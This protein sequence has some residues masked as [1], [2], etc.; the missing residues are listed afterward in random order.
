MEFG[1]VKACLASAGM[2]AA[3]YFYEYLKDIL[4]VLWILFGITFVW[5][6]YLWIK[7]MNESQN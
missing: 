3:I 6:G 5:P 1:L 7:K 2:I 4:P